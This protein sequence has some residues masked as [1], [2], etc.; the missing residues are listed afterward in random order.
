MNGLG[1]LI[2]TRSDQ[3]GLAPTPDTLPVVLALLLQTTRYP[4]P[5]GR[6]PWQFHGRSIPT[7][8]RRLILI[9]RAFVGACRQL[10]IRWSRQ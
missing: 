7:R 4:A 10:D 8:N 2:I 3:Q 5:V 6:P 9:L 1:V